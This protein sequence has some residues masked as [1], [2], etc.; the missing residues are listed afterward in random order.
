MPEE[1]P[2]PEV[3]HGELVGFELEAELGSGAFGT[4]YACTCGGDAGE[5]AVAGETIGDCMLRRMADKTD[6]AAMWLQACTATQSCGLVP[7]GVLPLS[8]H[9]SRKAGRRQP[10]PEN[11][12]HR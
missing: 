9:P 6:S 8:G 4:V 11:A 2:A 3:P 10:R 7:A 1:A 12:S 5:N